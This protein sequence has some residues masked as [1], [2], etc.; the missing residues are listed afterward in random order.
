MP[1]TAK[2]VYLVDAYSDPVVIRITGRASFQNSATINDFISECMRQGKTRFVIDFQDCESMDSTFLGV[3]AGAALKLRKCDSGSLVLAR[4]GKRNLE[5]ARNLGLQ[6]L[7]TVEC[8][9]FPMNFGAP[10]TP[11]SARAMTELDHAR[12]ALEAHENLLAADEGNRSKFQDVVAFLKNR[13][14]QK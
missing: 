4:M 12:L 7:A 13:V 8:G 9:D 2:P 14:E 5:L 11:L 1:E 3:L 6:H 10:N